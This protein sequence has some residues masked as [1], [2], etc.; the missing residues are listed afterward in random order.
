FFAD[1]FNGSPIAV[2]GILLGA[3]AS[4]DIPVSAVM[5]LECNGSVTGWAVV[6]AKVLG[7]PQTGSASANASIA[8][9]PLPQISV[10][11]TANQQAACAGAAVGF[12]IHVHNGSA[13]PESVFFADTF[14]GSP[15]AV[16]GILLGAGAS[17]DIPVSAVMPLVCNGS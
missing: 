5:P 15:I 16:P 17:L 6:T 2:P 12:V 11:K 7:C 1:T 8:C 4:L 13:A 14:N 9:V 3:G 10:T